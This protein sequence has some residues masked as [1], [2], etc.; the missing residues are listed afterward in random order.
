[1]FASE[2]QASPPRDSQGK[3]E[4]G[5]GDCLGCRITGGLFGALGSAFMASALLQTPPPR[6]AHKVGIIA[7]AGTVFVF[8]M[9]RA[10][11]PS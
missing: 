7:A 1:M 8:G 2:P 5:G 3:H 10:F 6:G 9:Y 4:K 11:G